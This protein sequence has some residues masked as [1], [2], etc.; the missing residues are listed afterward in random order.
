MVSQ[1]L[2]GEHV[3]ILDTQKSSGFSFVRCDPDDYEGWCNSVML[4]LIENE[5]YEKMQG[6]KK[7]ITRDILT[8]IPD[9]DGSSYL[10]LGAGSTLYLPDDRLISISGVNYEIPGGIL[11]GEQGKTEEQILSSA[12]KF[13]NIPYIWGGRSS[14]G[15]DCSGFVQNVFKQAGI[16]LPRDASQQAM[17]GQMISSLEESFPGDLLFFG[18]EDGNISHTGIFLG[19]NQIVHASCRVKV[20][21][22]DHQGIYSIEFQRY[23]HKLSV[24]RRILK[25]RQGGQ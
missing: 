1:V 13:V 14:F 22:V 20:D 16:L 6:L 23:T 25:S 19:N 15:T 7:V 21:S 5:E 9:V 2:F 10:F 17:C 24:I 11:P 18:N 8:I 3:T 12:R 4:Y